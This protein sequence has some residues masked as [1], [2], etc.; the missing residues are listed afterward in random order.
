MN[1]VVLVGGEGTRLRPLTY[2]TP[3]PMLPVAGL[4]LIERVIEPCRALPVT[5][6][7]LSLGYRPEA[8][9]RHYTDGKIGG[10]P[11]VYAIEPERLDTA[12]AIRFA[13]LEA[14]ITDT[15]VVLNGD[16]LSELDLAG[17]LAQHRAAGA[18]ATI[19]LSPVDDPSR[20]GVVPTHPDGRVIG[21]IE[22]PAPGEAPTN[23]I[24]AG[25]YILEASVLDRIPGGRPVS[26]EREVFPVMAAEGRLFAFADTGYW[27][28]TGT[29]EQFVQGNLDFVARGGPP[30]PG[31]VE[32]GVGVWSLGAEVRGEVRGPALLGHGVVV[33]AGAVVDGA[34]LG[35][36]VVVGEGATVARTVALDRAVIGPRANLDGALLGAG[37]TVGESAKVTGCTVVGDGAAIAAN[38]TIDDGRVGE[39]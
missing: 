34:V 39:P 37:S 8:F 11:I 14:G 35:A 2:T 5:N 29:P 16:V 21:F 30:V 23:L 31:A 15:F 3:K 36:G 33:G 27:L 13:A 22:K 18:E 38:E 7:V 6:V 17:L 26:I 28:D 12:G 20:F 19:A 24:N 25:A 32:L 4:P 10:H 9:Q 1:V